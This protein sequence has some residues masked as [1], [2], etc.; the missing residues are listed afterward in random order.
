M[1]SRDATRQYNL[2]RALRAPL[3]VLVWL[4]YSSVYPLDCTMSSLLPIRVRPRW[5]LYSVPNIRRRRFSRD[6]CVRRG[7]H[8]V[9]ALGIWCFPAAR[10]TCGV[11]NTGLGYGK[12][13][14][15]DLG[16]ISYARAFCVH[17]VGWAD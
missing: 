7:S 9:H 14:I 15:G 8:G 6:V 16:I 5:H 4:D 12:H 10:W 13:G 3:A 2:R 11:R 1:F 17:K